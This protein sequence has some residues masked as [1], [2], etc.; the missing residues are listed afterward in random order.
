M[1][2]ASAIPEKKTPWNATFFGGTTDPRESLKTKSGIPVSCGAPNRGYAT[3]KFLGLCQK[4][5]EGGGE[6]KRNKGGGAVN[7]KKN[8]G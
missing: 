7:Q 1:L 8:E 5:E 3:Q 6:V 2:L 4:M